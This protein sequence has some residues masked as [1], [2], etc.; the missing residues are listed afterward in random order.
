MFWGKKIL[1]G[2]GALKLNLTHDESF[3]KLQERF[4]K[5]NLAE[6]LVTKLL[7]GTVFSIISDLQGSQAVTEKNLF[8]E[9]QRLIKKAK[10][11]ELLFI[12]LQGKTKRLVFFLDQE[13]DLVRKHSED[14]ARC[15]DRPQHLNLLQA[16]NKREFEVDRYH[17]SKIPFNKIK[18]LSILRHFLKE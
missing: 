6:K 8:N 14:E 11:N 13:S 18:F 5:D 15:A 1:E 2:W 3:R 4:E 9:R 7:D 16:T 12:L 10:G 17:L